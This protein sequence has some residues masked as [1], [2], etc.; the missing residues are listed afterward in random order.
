M[1]ERHRGAGKAGAFATVCLAMGLAVSP[2][3][4]QDRVSAHVGAVFP[5]I[6]HANGETIDIG[7]DFKVGFP[8]GITIKKTDTIA[9]DL[10]LVPVLDPND[11]S[12]IGVPLT[13]HPGVLKSLGGSWTAG[14]RMAFDIGGASWGFTP[15]INRGFPADGYTPFVELVVPIRFQD[16]SAGDTHGAIGLGVH[17]GV[18]F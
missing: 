3:S 18:G 16:D 8:I 2:A 10:E 7:D 9:F 17:V 6:T 13:I 11:N 5:L 1:F 12:P 14:L 15:L 4:A